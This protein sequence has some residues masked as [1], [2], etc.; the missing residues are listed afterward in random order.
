[1]KSIKE[2]TKENFQSMFNLKDILEDSVF[3]PAAGIDAS[4]IE[5]LSN[6]YC[7]FIHVDYSTPRDVVEPGMKH[8]F[9][10]VGYDLIGLKQ[11]SEKELTPN[12]FT[13]RNFAIN[14]HERSRLEMEFINDRFRCRNFTPFALWAVY[15]LN[16]LKT[17]KSQGKSNR[18]SLLHIGGEAC[19]TFEAIYISN[20]INPRCIS[21][22]SPG[23]GFG[24]NWTI[25]RD[26]NFR[27]YQNLLF[28]TV[29]NNAIMPD[30][31]LTNMALSDNEDCFWPD[32]N[33]QDRCFANGWQ[34]RFSRI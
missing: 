29:N 11:V 17:G 26:P 1:M 20:K 10:G 34:R 22:I 8:H 31:L 33:Y 4:D 19:A 6:Q 28:N 32:Y 9:E 25:F 18:F 7:S 15:E 3:Y 23:E 12:G 14:E 16:P 21:I 27:L 30:A 5:C 24:D 2:I 13:P